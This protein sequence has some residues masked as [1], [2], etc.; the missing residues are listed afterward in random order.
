MLDPYLVKSLDAFMRDTRVRTAVV[1]I[2]AAEMLTHLNAKR[3]LAVALNSWMSAP[4]ATTT[5]ASCSSTSSA[6]TLWP[7]SSTGSGMCRG[8]PIHH[9]VWACRRDPRQ[10]WPSPPHTSIRPRQAAETRHT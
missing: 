4:G 2:D 5:C 1:V 8:H 9:H 7:R 6:P 3:E 10:A